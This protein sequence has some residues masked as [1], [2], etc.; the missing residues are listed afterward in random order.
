MYQRLVF[1]RQRSSA[2]RFVLLDYSNFY[3]LLCGRPVGRVMSLARPSVCPSVCLA[4]ARNRKTKERRKIRIGIHVAHGTSKWKRSKV[5]V[6]GKTFRIWRNAYLRAA[7]PADR[8]RQ[9][10]TANY[11]QPLLGLIHGRPHDARAPT[12]KLRVRYSNH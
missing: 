4:R 2:Q 9:A 1:R 11:A 7:A 5:K 12:V 3:R 6:T 10:P 8:A